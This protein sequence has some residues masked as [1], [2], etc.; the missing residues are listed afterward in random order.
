MGLLFTPLGLTRNNA[1]RWLGVEGFG[2]TI[3]PGEIAKICAIIFVSWYLSKDPGRIRSFTRGVL[4][5]LGV[6]GIYFLLIFKQPNLSTALTICMVIVGIMFV[7]GL[8][9]FLSLIHI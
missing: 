2:F 5:M 8:H 4:P 9:W 7:A 1:T 3:M 6:C